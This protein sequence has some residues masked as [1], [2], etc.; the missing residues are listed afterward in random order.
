MVT[1]SEVCHFVGTDE[2]DPDESSLIT[3]LIQSS[4]NLIESQT[5]IPLS[6]GISDQII[7]SL[8]DTTVLDMV[9]F[10]Y[11]NS[12]DD[13]KKTEFL[14]SH[15]NDNIFTLQIMYLRKLAKDGAEGV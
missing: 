5:N 6:G 11:F 3:R 9:Y 15:I 14:Q 10:N 1:L 2:N 12:R 8:V 4:Y 7:N 13:G